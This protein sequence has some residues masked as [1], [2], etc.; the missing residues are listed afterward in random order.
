MDWFLYDKTSATK[1]INL[2]NLKDI[3]QLLLLL[4]MTIEVG[5]NNSHTN[6]TSKVFAGFF[7]LFE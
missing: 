7:V 2:K 6:H 4:T 5:A 1:E 3:F